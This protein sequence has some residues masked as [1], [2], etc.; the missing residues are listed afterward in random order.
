MAPVTSVVASNAIITW[1]AP[2]A[3]GTP[4][5]GYNIYIRQADLTYIFNNAVCDGTTLAV[6]SGT[7]SCTI[8]LSTLTASP[9]SLLLGFSI[10]SYVVAYN[11]YGNSVAS[12]AG[13]GG[14]IVLVPNAPVSL[15]NLP[16]ITTKSVIGFSWMN[17]VSNG[18]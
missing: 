16:S 12:P 10:N 3:N 2:F 7:T 14:I 8:P 18:G 11:A 1:T 5:T 4:L 13:N 9:Y 17:G 15:A 6:V